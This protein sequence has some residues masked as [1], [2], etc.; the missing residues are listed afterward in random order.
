M[1]L[2]WKKPLLSRSTIADDSKELGATSAVDCSVALTINQRLLLNLN[3]ER[4]FF[5]LS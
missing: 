3:G 5:N 4:S 2:E 1:V